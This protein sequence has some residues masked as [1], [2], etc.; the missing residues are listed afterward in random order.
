MLIYIAAPYTQGNIALNVRRAI[1]AGE[2]V[3]YHGHTPFIP[4]LTHLWDL[5]CPKSW[6]EWMEIDKV[7][8][9]KC[10]G[11]LRLP[12]DSKGADI[13]VEWAREMNIP[14][15]HDIKEMG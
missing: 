12:G 2:T 11:L 10:D 6:N 7:Y 9:S 13:E 3:L 1:F 14:V 8:L 15:Y 4:H 5:L